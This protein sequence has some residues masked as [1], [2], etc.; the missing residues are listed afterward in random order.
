MV[1]SSLGPESATSDAA[2]GV[3]ADPEL[4]APTRLALYSRES[5]M[6]LAARAWP[7]GVLSMSLSA[8]LSTSASASSPSASSS[9]AAHG[10]TSTPNTRC[11]I[12]CRTA[13]ASRSGLVTSRYASSICVQPLSDSSS[14][15]WDAH[16][17]MLVSENLFFSS[18]LPRTVPSEAMRASCSFEVAVDSDA[19]S[20]RSAASALV[21]VPST[22]C[23]CAASDDCTQHLKLAGPGQRP[24][25]NSPPHVPALVL[26]HTPPTCAHLRSSLTRSGRQHMRFA[27]PP[28][29]PDT[30]SQPSRVHSDASRHPAS[31]S[32]TA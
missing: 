23:R 9:S 10:A 5:T 4:A 12:D 2:P 28:H 11:A 15:C 13:C 29:M 25:R 21:Y 14:G 27:P 31:G 6:S 1:A 20:P 24:L 30:G 32:S 3:S 26:M 18:V 8:T 17:I 16:V 22:D 19:P 7:A